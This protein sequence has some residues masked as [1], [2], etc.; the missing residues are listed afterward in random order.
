ME[1]AWLKKTA[2]LSPDAQLLLTIPGIGELS[3]LVIIAELGDV[4]RFKRAAQ[5]A[6]YVGLVPSIYSS[7]DVRRIGALTKQ[8]P[9]L[10]RWMLIQCAWQAI[11]SS[12]PLR[13]HFT[14]VT[15]RSGR[16]AGIVSIARKLIQIA[17]RVLRD[18]KE[19]APQL[20]GKTAA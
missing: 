5:V 4:N 20:V 3:A 17:Y 7:A 6:S 19:F 1:E 10:L 12:Y 9:S 2:K 18:K 14:S 16:N 13:C 11:K 15:R 8:G